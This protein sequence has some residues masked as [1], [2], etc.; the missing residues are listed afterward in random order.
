MYVCICITNIYVCG[1]VLGGNSWLWDY[2]LSFEI[3]AGNGDLVDMWLIVVGGC[4]KPEPNFTH[5][6]LLSRKG[7]FLLRS[8]CNGFF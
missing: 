1:G 5:S 4:G 8:L 3:K 7:D 2:S 6:S